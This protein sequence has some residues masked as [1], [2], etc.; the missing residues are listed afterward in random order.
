ML[1]QSLQSTQHSEP[2]VETG[3]PTGR[4]NSFAVHATRGSIV[5]LRHRGD[6]RPQ[7]ADALAVPEVNGQLPLFA[8]A[9]RSGGGLPGVK[10]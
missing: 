8:R 5:F 3:L 6:A 1:P 9:R 2:A 10:V 4:E 7:S